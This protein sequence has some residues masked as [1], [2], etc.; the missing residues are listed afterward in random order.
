MKRKKMKKHE[1]KA[2]HK[3]KVK[4]GE[5][6]KYDDTDMETANITLVEGPFAGVIFQFGSIEFPAEEKVENFPEDGTVPL[7]INFNVVSVPNDLG[8][9]EDV[10]ENEEFKTLIGDYVIE[11]LE[12]FVERNE[13]RVGKE[14]EDID[15]DKMVERGYN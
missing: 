15:D 12:D 4:I 13:G 8:T 2:K 1:S 10:E 5:V 6:T 3:S 9:I 14:E 11:M 7:T